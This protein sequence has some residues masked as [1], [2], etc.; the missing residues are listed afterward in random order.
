MTVNG[1][2]VHGL[3]SY[4]F[5]YGL[6]PTTV[7]DWLNH[8]KPLTPALSPSEGEREIFRPRQWLAAIL[9]VIISTWYNF[10]VIEPS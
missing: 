7:E 1:L 6:I 2:P 8:R 5:G 3:I 4:P 9:P 10:E